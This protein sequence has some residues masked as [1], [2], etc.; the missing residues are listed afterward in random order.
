MMVRICCILVFVADPK[1]KSRGQ[2]DGTAFLKHPQGA[3]DASADWAFT[4][5]CCEMA[6][7][8]EPLSLEPLV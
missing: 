2:P 5:L 6:T 4:C 7:L 3:E 1:K 8:L